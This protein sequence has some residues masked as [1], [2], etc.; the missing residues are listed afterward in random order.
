RRA[1]RRHLRRRRS[2]CPAPAAAAG[3]IGEAAALRAADW[4]SLSA[5]ARRVWSGAGG[6]VRRGEVENRRWRVGDRRW[7]TVAITVGCV[8]WLVAP[9]S[10]AGASSA[11]ATQ[12]G[13]RGQG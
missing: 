2:R 12:P 5:P 1:G 10:P 9:L 8:L 3:G 13:E 11:E 7:R 6:E 4:S